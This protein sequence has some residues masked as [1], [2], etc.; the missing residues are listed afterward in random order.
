MFHEELFKSIL[1]YCFSVCSVGVSNVEYS[2]IK[3]HSGL[4]CCAAATLRNG[5]M[6]MYLHGLIYLQG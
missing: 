3:S 1:H 6:H 5:E 4:T 2:Y